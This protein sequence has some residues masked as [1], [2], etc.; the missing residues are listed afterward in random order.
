MVSGLIPR[1]EMYVPGAALISSNAGSRNSLRLKSTVV[2]LLIAFGTSGNSRR[3]L[4]IC[5][6]SNA[7]GNNS[8][9]TFKS[10]F[11]SMC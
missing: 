11:Q 9:S 8:F 4:R 1:A 5:S 6:L 7:V 10:T 2:I 3:F